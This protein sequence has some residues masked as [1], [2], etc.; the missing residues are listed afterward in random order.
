M[1]TFTAK[2]STESWR[3][4]AEGPLNQL[5]RPIMRDTQGSDA[6]ANVIDHH[7]KRVT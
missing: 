5:S 4:F 2:S 7:G 6:Q 3:F 1:V